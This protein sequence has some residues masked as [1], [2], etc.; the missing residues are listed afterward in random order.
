MTA[1]KEKAGLVAE[2]Q[3]KV[4]PVFFSFSFLFLGSVLISS[5]SASVP[6]LALLLWRGLPGVSRGH[7][8]RRERGL[9]P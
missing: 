7:T 9:M 4:W 8:N 1:I 2:T 6:S 3:Q 5:P